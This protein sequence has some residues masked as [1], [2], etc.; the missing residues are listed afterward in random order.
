M[1]IRIFVTKSDSLLFHL[2]LILLLSSYAFGATRAHVADL[3]SG[4]GP[5]EETRRL[6]ID[7]CYRNNLL[8]S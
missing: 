1:I 6:Y 3:H 5:L 8:S 7:I 4:V 2:L